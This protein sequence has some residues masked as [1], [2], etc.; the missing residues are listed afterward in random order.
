MIATQDEAFQQFE[1]TLARIEK[2][3]HKAR[4]EARVLL[5]EQLKFLRQAHHEELKVIRKLDQKVR[6]KVKA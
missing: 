5:R 4:E 2:Q 1:E 3:A 6:G